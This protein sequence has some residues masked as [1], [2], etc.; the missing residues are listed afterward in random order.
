MKRRIA[1]ASVAITTIGGL[2]LASSARAGT[3]TVNHTRGGTITIS[4]LTLS[5]TF[6]CVNVTDINDDTGPD[7][8]FSPMWDFKVVENGQTAWKYV[9]L[10]Y[11]LRHFEETG[12]YNPSTGKWQI[13]HLVYQRHGIGPSNSVWN[14]DKVVA[15]LIG[16]GETEIDGNTMYGLGSA[17]GF[18]FEASKDGTNWKPLAGAYAWE[19]GSVTLN[20]PAMFSCDYRPY[21]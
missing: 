13:D 10:N 20:K 11:L 1:L 6:G 9:R 4:G 15:D 3:S 18:Q 16:D 19:N 14:P 21:P 7:A 5:Y 2:L 17:V 8:W 12:S